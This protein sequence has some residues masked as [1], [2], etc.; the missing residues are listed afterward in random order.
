MTRYNFNIVVNNKG[1]HSKRCEIQ[2][3]SFSKLENILFTFPIISELRW[4]KSEVLKAMTKKEREYTGQNTFICYVIGSECE[5]SS[6]YDKDNITRISTITVLDF[7]DQAIEFYE[8]YDNGEIQSI[9]PESK[10]EDWVIV[11]KE[12]IKDEFGS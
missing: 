10:K 12:F 1:F 6:E 2:P 9:I 5:L 4:F 3:L 8:L 11:P 7:I